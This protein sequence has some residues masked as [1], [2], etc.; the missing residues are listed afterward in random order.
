MIPPKT[1]SDVR[2]TTKLLMELNEHSLAV[3]RL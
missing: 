2:A 3:F 1:L